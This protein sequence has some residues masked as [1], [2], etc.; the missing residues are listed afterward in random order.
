MIKKL[1]IAFILLLACAA[2]VLFMHRFYV[3]QYTV[4]TLIRKALPDYVRVDKIRLEP[5]RHSL[6]LENFRIV[7]PGN[8]SY[9]Y[10]FEIESM[11]CKYKLKGRSILDG[12][13]IFEPEFK[14]PTLTIETV[15]YTHLTLPT[16]RIV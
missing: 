3:L 6:V 10:L 13:E 5:E 9:P 4:E 15:S 7:N 16:K 12:F 11:S 8:F 1:I 14:A 2:A